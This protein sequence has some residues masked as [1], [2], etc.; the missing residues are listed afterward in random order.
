M[1]IADKTRNSI[2]KRQLIDTIH[3]IAVG[4][5]RI[6]HQLGVIVLGQFAI[7]HQ[8]FPV[9]HHSPHVARL[10]AV[11]DLAEDIVYRLIVDGIRIDED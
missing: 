7:A 11:D 10:G 3:Q 8:N 2:L 4:L 6:G 9:D 1:R 5:P